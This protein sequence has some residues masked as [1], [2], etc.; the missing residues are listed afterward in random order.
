M[1]PYIFVLIFVLL[2]A[3]GAQ[4]NE[5]PAAAARDLSGIKTL[6]L[7]TAQGIALKDNPSMAAAMARVR[8][9]RAREIGRA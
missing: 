3:G 2:A 1:K 7:A 8:Q 4:G 5:Q 6:D 9:A